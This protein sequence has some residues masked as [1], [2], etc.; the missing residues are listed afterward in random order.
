MSNIN[1]TC[2]KVAKC[3]IFQKGV[4]S[5]EKTG[6][7]YKSIFCQSNRHKE[8]KRFLAAQVCNKPIPVQVLPNAFISVD[9]IVKR[10]ENGFYDV[11]NK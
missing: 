9:E 7:T 5:N 4:L 1:E 11:F 2:P 6:E 10:V 3:P 8:C